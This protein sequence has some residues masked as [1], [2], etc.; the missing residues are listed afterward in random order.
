MPGFDGTGPQGRGPLTGRARGYCVLRESKDEPIH[1]QGFA[2]VQGTPVKIPEGKEV[3]DM[4]LENRV[5]PMISRPMVCRPVS[6]P[7]WGNANP[8]LMGTVPPLGLYQPAPYTYRRSWWSRGFW[9]APFGGLV[10][11]GRGCGRGRGR[12]RCQW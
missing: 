4:P 12:F 7:G 10:G 2:G 3:V 1:M 9:R 6:Y 8:L 5:G 11:S